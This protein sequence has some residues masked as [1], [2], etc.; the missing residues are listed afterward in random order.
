[1]V[2]AKNDHAINITFLSIDLFDGGNLEDITKALALLTDS[3]TKK[4][5]YYA[6]R[7]RFSE[8][9]L[10]RLLCSLPDS[11]VDDLEVKTLWIRQRIKKVSSVNSLQLDDI[12][13]HARS[14][15]W[16]CEAEL[17]RSN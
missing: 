4:L 17:K 10:Q 7:G 5:L 11:T 1:L 13:T 12:K 8:F 2:E 9:L 15:L 6:K 14:I 3:D 16:H